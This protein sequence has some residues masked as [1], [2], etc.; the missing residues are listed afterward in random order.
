M[1]QIIFPRKEP[2]SRVAKTSTT[3]YNIVLVVYAYIKY[4]HKVNDAG[5][6]FSDYSIYMLLSL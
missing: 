3:N 5:K 1:S 6:T 4:F 2:A